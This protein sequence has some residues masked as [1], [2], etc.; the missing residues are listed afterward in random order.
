MR[1]GMEQQCPV[2]ERRNVSMRR[3]KNLY[4]WIVTPAGI[5]CECNLNVLLVFGVHVYT[6]THNDRF[7]YMFSGKWMHRI[8]TMAVIWLSDGALAAVLLLLLWT[9]ICTLCQSTCS[10]HEYWI[11]DEKILFAVVIPT[12]KYFGV[13]NNF[14]CGCCCFPSLLLLLCYSLWLNRGREEEEKYAPHS[15]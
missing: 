10:A 11:Y 12:H 14:R 7:F 3:K 2:Y 4:K 6:R 5:A 9:Q 15:E 1:D 13:W 8:S